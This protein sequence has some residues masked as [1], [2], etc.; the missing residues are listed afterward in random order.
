MELFKLTAAARRLIILV[1]PRHE[2]SGC[3][4]CS[5]HDHDPCTEIVKIRTALRHRRRASQSQS[6][7]AT[8][9]SFS[10]SGPRPP[11]NGLRYHR[12]EHTI[13]GVIGAPAY[14]EFRF[15]RSWE[16]VPGEWV[17]HAGRKI[18]MQKFCVTDA[19]SPPHESGPL[20]R[21]TVHSRSDECRLASP[22]DF[23]SRSSLLLRP[24][25]ACLVFSFF[26]R[27][28]VSL[29]SEPRY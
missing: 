10:R 17:L 9:N 16:I 12:S 19:E 22:D 4:S 18:G 25:P 29:G 20:Q 14:R 23:R 24:R 21:R 7:R 3:V 13:Q 26:L 27:P 5:E 15:D 2:C 8:R 6:E 1:W 28:R 11:V